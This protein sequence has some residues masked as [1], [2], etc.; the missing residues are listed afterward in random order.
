MTKLEE[1]PNCCMS[2][3]IDTQELFEQMLILTS[4]TM[5]SHIAAYQVLPFENR[6][7]LNDI[8]NAH[9]GNALICCLLTPIE[10]IALSKTNLIT[11]AYTDVLLMQ[12]FILHSESLQSTESWVP[13]CLP[14][15][16]A[17]G[18]LQMYS[19]F[20][21]RIGVV[22]IT[23]SQEYEYFAKFAEKSRVII[24]ELT[25][26]QL[27][28]KIEKNLK[29][30]NDV[31]DIT[32]DTQQMDDLY[33]KLFQLSV[34]NHDTAYYY[35]DSKI[36]NIYNDDNEKNYIMMPSLTEI[37]PDQKM[38]LTVKSNANNEENQNSIK[39]NNDQVPP[40]TKSSIPFSEN[41]YRVKDIKKD[42]L[43]KIKYAICKH[44]VF[45]QYFSINF[46]PI[47][48]ITNEE[49][50]IY[51][52]YGRLYDLYNSQVTS[53]I[54]TNNFFHFEKDDK[55]SHCI[56]TS[57]NYILMAS[58]NLF[59]PFDEIHSIGKDMLKVVKSYESNFFINIK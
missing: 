51:E 42:P 46:G 31:N 13:L 27:L 16:S 55:F 58:F 23:E 21:D 28:L 15:I 3:L 37:K 40:M 39:N 5:V 48:N 29:L 32:F 20:T 10:I 25:D 11:L 49:F 22:F 24:Q 57:D 50:Y 17:E 38:P 59:M 33:I 52:S 26:K 18:Y 35:R 30:K 53:L 12:N 8:C 6:Y 47:A 1:N 19:N 43:I 44:K 36:N 7:K 14:G 41:V 54:N 9:R 56:F 4:S 2:T 45:N 34:N